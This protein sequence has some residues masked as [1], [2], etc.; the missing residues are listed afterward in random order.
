M[1]DNPKDWLKKKWVKNH[2]RFY[3][4]AAELGHPLQK[5]S[6]RRGTYEVIK[7]KPQCD[8]AL[9]KILKINTTSCYICGLKITEEG[10]QSMESPAGHQCEHILTASTIGM[11]TGLPGTVSNVDI[12]DAES[13][14]IINELMNDSTKGDT[15]VKFYSDYKVFQKSIWPLLYDWSHPACNEH[16]DNHPFLRIDFKHSGLRVL[17]LA[18]T[19]DNI[20]KLLAILFYRVEPATKKGTKVTK[21]RKSVL[22]KQRHEGTKGQYVMSRYL[23]IYQKIE[24]IETTLKGYDPILLK[25]YSYLSTKTMLNIIINNVLHFG[26][27]KWV[28]PLRKLF[29]SSNSLKEYIERIKGK[30]TFKVPDKLLR[31]LS[32][33]G[34]GKDQLI[35]YTE[36]SL[37]D[38]TIMSVLFLLNMSNPELFTDMGIDTT[39]SD[40]EGIDVSELIGEKDILPE[41]VEVIYRFK[42]FCEF[43][44]RHIN[45]DNSIKYSLTPELYS[46]SELSADVVNHT[47]RKEVIGMTNY[48]WNEYA[49]EYNLEEAIVNGSSLT[50]DILEQG[51]SV[52]DE[53]LEH[54]NLIDTLKLLEGMGNELKDEVTESEAVEG[55]L[56]LKRVRESLGQRDRSSHSEDVNKRPRG[57]M[58]RTKRTNKTKRMKRTKKKPKKVDPMKDMK[59]DLRSMKFMIGD[60]IVSF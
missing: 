57:N 6:R 17:P 26:K 38:D 35:Y 56:G 60:R 15:Y 31:F 14:D 23:S 46:E 34:G 19:S 29:K 30:T 7:T 12:Y 27:F 42:Q 50:T 28:K 45:S 18:T 44:R 40:L 55:L 58:K 48:I 4:S 49:R 16:K 1:S 25:H 32:Q 22:L 8:A 37:P 43:F 47:F 59:R 36:E 21:W 11:L 24:L 39:M 33:K 9:G 10:G 13:R 2:V 54:M 3:F 51:P 20:K 52:D 53:S 41:N 5:S